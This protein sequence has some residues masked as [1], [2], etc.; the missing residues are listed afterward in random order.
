MTV[1]MSLN[2][3]HLII[4]LAGKC[5]SL[6]GLLMEWGGIVLKCPEVDVAELASSCQFGELLNS[7]SS[8]IWRNSVLR[9]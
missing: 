4:F 9:C 3:E 1:L 6:A 8:N 7:N 2:I 5:I